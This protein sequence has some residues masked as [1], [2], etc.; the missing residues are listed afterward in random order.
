VDYLLL[1]LSFF[2]IITDFEIVEFDSMFSYVHNRI[3][4]TLSFPKDTT[5]HD[6][7]LF[8]KVFV[9]IVLLFLY[10]FCTLWKASRFCLHSLLNHGLLLLL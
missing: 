7:T 9:S 10:L 6:D 4:F 2:D 5:N 3:H 1:S 8:S